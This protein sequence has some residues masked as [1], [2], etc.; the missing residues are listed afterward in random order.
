MATRVRFAPSPTGEVHIGN[1]R[2]AIFN[3]LYARHTGGEF[4]LRIEDTDRERSTPEAIAALLDVMTWL[5]LDYD[6]EPLYQSSQRD[7]HTAAAEELLAAGKA[8]RHAKGDGGEATLFRIPWNTDDIPEVRDAGEVRLK[9]H[10]ETPVLIDLTGVTYALVS[11]KGKPHEQAGSLGGFRGLQLFNAGGD[12]IY[13]LE[14]DID[15]V[16][17]GERR[18]IA[19]VTEMLF[20]RREIVY[21]DEVKGELAKPLD[22]LKD[23]VIVRSDGSPV[24]HLANVCDDVTQGITHILRGDDHVENTYR[25]ILLFRALGAEPPA[26]GHFPMIVNEA[27]KPYSKRDGDAYVGDFRNKGYLAQALYNYLTLLGWSPGDDREK[28]SRDELVA[29]FT[30]ERVTSA[31]AQMDIRKVDNVNG[32]YIADMAPA[33]F[34]ATIEPFVAVQQWA[35]DAD[36]ELLSAVAGLMQSRCKLFA[37]VSDWY[38]FFTDELSYNEKAVRKGLA[39]DGV[40]AALRYLAARLDTV[41]Q[42]GEEPVEAAV[43]ATTDEV[44][45]AQGK[46]NLPIRV[47]VTGTNV[48]AGLYETMALLGQA[49]CRQRLQYAIDNLCG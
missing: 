18:E 1:I 38:Y 15:A 20:Q 13:E 14:P 27:G 11:K 34:M 17:N 33:E 40:A 45:I 24:F 48:G 6:E 37:D 41:E 21:A 30:L 32:L 44:G 47:A 9:L 25:H 28:M 46:L 10:Q 23:Q 16:L 35:A 26:Y 12:R 7:H 36:S 31:A 22:S 49:R 2:T 5:G 42:Y 8:Y 4:L 43:H 39:K 29:A 19:G 3:W